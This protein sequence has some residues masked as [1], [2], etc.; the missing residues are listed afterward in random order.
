MS[1]RT[2]DE[3]DGFA[4]NYRSIHTGNIK[5]SGADSYYFAKMKVEYLKPFEKNET[6]SVLDV[7]CGDGAT[8]LFM[9]ELFPRWKVNA[10]DVS[11]QSIEEAKKKNLP[12]VVF[13]S[14]DGLKIP[15]E[16]DSFDMVFIAGVLHHVEKK[17]HQMIIDEIKRVLKKNGRVYLFE[18]NPLN[19][20]T[21]YLV[22]TCVFDKDAKLLKSN[23]TTGV[24]KESGLKITH[25]N[26]IIFFPRK[27]WLSKFILL[28]K[29]LKW[30]PLG[31]QYFFRAFK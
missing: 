4:E 27:G 6:F 21:R 18:H 15:F 9:N 31:G 26:F 5:L 7:G 19:P 16:N 30:L 11:V 12:N 2:F 24:L 23:Y 3:F 28:E 25:K 20:F 14:Y 8:E 10:I 17:F 13:N 29:K 1:E 22:N